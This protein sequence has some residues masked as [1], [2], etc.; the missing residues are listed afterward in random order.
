ML[1]PALGQN[2]IPKSILIVG[3]GTAGWMAASILLHAWRDQG[4]K[5]TLVESEDI[6]IIGVGEGSTPALRKFFGYLKVTEREWMP[7]CNATYKA[8]IQFNGWSTIKG[9]ENYFHPFYSTFDIEHS[10]DFFQNVNVRRQ[11]FAAEAHPDNY[12]LAAELARQ[13]KAPAPVEREL[14]KHIEYG[15]HFDSSLLGK[16]LRDRA[17]K[18]GLAHVIDNVTGVKLNGEGEI[19]SVATQAHAELTADFY[20][21]CTGFAGLLINKAL[22]EPVKSFKENLFN[23]S[24]VTIT[25]DIDPQK[26]S[27]ATISTAMPHG[28]VWKIPLTNRHGNGYVYSA[29]F[30]SPE[31]AEIELRNH[32]GAAATQQPTRH[33]KMRVGRVENHWKKN[34]LAVGLSQGF[35]EPLE[36]TALAIV[37]STLEN[38][39]DSFDQLVTPDTLAKFNDYINSL[40]DGIRDYIVTH[41]FLN[42][43][44]DTNYWIACREQTK[45]SDSLQRLISAWDSR[46]NVIDVLFAQNCQRIYKPES[47]FCI[48]AGM[49][50]FPEIENLAPNKSTDSILKSCRDIAEQMFMDHRQYLKNLPNL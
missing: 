50:R 17:K 47:W 41:Y 40:I 43:R 28:W 25:T 7:A 8:G 34:C 32:L 6:G 15:Y 3:G 42:T 27:S 38:F 2:S 23:D 37:Q 10:Q 11:G 26:T 13:H 1:K 14:T 39:V 36:A 9:Y 46:E 49:G 21:D 20:I 4:V 5:I 31:Q 19:A 24:A 48:L 16:F 35:I 33:L 18:L 22:Q 29:D 12:F 44:T 30:I 45:L